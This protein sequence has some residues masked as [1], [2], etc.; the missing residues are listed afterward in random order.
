MEYYRV[1]QQFIS[2][3][4]MQ[5]FPF[6]FLCLSISPFSSIC[7]ATCCVYRT[8]FTEN[9]RKIYAFSQNQIDIRCTCAYHL[10]WF[11]SFNSEYPANALSNFYSPHDDVSIFILC[12]DEPFN[13]IAEY[14]I[15][16]L[17]SPS[18]TYTL[19]THRSYSFD[20]LHLVMNRFCNSALILH[21]LTLLYYL[22]PSVIDTM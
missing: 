17:N 11:N 13:A 1:I 4:V 6:L 2:I 18:H 10:H 12:S 20:Q 5:S 15:E 3:C 8:L 14:S 16:Q 22:S 9:S 19:H 7:S 21:I